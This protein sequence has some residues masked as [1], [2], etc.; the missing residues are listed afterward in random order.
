M[1][2][3]CFASSIWL[4]TADLLTGNRLDVRDFRKEYVNKVLREDEE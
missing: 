3:L 4:K 1:A 2:C